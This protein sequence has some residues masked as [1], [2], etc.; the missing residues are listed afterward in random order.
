MSEEGKTE[1]LEAYLLR[2]VLAETKATNARVGRLEESVSHALEAVT[3]ARATDRYVRHE[4]APQLQALT[5]QVNEALT[6]SRAAAAYVQTQAKPRF[7]KHGDDI[8]SLKRARRDAVPPPADADAGDDEGELPTGEY[9]VSPEIA[10][11]MKGLEEFRQRAER[12]ESFFFRQRHG[13]IYAVA[14][15]LTIAVLTGSA[16][17]VLTHVSAKESAK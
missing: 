3:V 1:S 10:A 13:A 14:I 5:P 16:T 2:Q 8:R 17:Y 6:L 7:D 12:R 15:A 4:I 11:T 9:P